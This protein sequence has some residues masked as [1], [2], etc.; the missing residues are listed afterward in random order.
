MKERIGG[1]LK[2]KWIKGK[3]RKE[4]KKAEKRNI[5]GNNVEKEQ[6]EQRWKTR[7]RRYFMERVNGEKRKKGKRLEGRQCMG[8]MMEKQENKEREHMKGRKKSK[9]KKEE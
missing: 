9:A 6:K 2:T 7:R 5:T 1:L 8:E 3:Q 4:T